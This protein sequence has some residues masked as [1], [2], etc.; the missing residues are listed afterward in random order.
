MSKATITLNLATGEA[1]VFSTSPNIKV[2]MEL[3][4]L[5]QMCDMYPDN[6]ELRDKVRNLESSI[7]KELNFWKKNFG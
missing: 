1:R 4:K 3:A 7:H 2:I 5:Q 6:L